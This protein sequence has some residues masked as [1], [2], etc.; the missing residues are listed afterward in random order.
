V[1]SLG[2]GIVRGD[3]VRYN[4]IIHGLI[5][6]LHD[7]LKVS[8]HDVLHNNITIANYITTYAPPPL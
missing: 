4:I 8:G 3:V 1:H 7:C 2:D 5:A 6:T